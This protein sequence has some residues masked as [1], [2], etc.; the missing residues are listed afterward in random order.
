MP[1]PID[2]LSKARRRGYDARRAFER[3]FDKEYKLNAEWLIVL[4]IA[5]GALIVFIANL[6]VK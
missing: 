2:Q 5:I 1:K 4:G 3:K 6:L